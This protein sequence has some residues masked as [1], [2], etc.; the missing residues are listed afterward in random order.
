MKIFEN[1]FGGITVDPSTLPE[2]APE[3]QQE[4]SLLIRQ[5]SQKQLLWVKIALEKSHLIP[6]LTTHGF[7]FHHCEEHFITLVRKQHPGAFVPT[8]KNYIV[9]VGAIVRN[10][11]CLLV[12]KDRFQSGYKLPG[13]HVDKDETI[14]EALKREVWEETGIEVAFES[15]LN[16]GHFRNGQFGESNIY[17]VCTAKPLSTDI[18]IRDTSEIVDACWMHI[19][20]FLQ[21]PEVNNYNKSV[22]RAAL[23]NK[24]LKLVE[25]Q[26]ELRIAGGEIFF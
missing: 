5:Y 6:V 17:M 25:Q 18:H 1:Q 4:I 19:D 15:I 8:T 9:G 12:I 14:K 11:D 10:Q 23:A 13:G 22:V 16:V 24:E 21:M 3:F 20:E 26:V 7:E 2:N